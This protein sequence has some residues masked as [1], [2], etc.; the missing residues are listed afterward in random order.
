MAVCFAIDVGVVPL[1][2][3][4]CCCCCCCALPLDEDWLLVVLVVVDGI[5]KVV[6]VV[7]AVVVP[8]PPVVVVVPS[9]LVLQTSEDL[10]ISCLASLVLVDGL[11][12]FIFI[13]RLCLSSSALLLS[14][15]LF[16]E[17]VGV[18]V[19]GDVVDEE[20]LTPVVRFVAVELRL[21]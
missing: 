17:G 15:V 4:C 10:T 8:A 21:M 11:V 9:S 18:T 6:V 2:C 3:C 16:E 19:V 20:F 14:T 5:G 1:G 7:V 13:L 12:L